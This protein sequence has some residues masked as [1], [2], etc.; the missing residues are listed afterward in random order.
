M[1]STVADGVHRPMLLDVKSRLRRRDVSRQGPFDL[2]FC[3]SKLF[4]AWMVFFGVALTRLLLASLAVSKL[5][6]VSVIEIVLK[7]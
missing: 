4:A 7:S 6:N 5:S 3:Q 2:R 1:R